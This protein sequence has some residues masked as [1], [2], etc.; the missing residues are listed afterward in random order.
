MYQVAGWLEMSLNY[1]GDQEIAM[2][3]AP[4]KLLHFGM[5]ALGLALI[6]CLGCRPPLSDF[7]K[8]VG[9]FFTAHCHAGTPC[10]FK[11]TD[12]TNFSWDT[13]YAFR[14]G[15][16]QTE[17]ENV[18]GRPI[19]DFVPSTRKIIFLQGGK[20]V[21]VVQAPSKSER[22]VPQEMIFQVSPMSNYVSYN[23]QTSFYLNQ[24]RLSDLTYYFPVVR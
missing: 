2:R 5:A 15:V 21:Y 4:L 24:G 6:C 11:I 12:V 17:V 20:V 19:P 13:M 8:D 3:N 22:I 14:Y 1:T 18:I 9:R 23:S 10:T 16:S 7:D